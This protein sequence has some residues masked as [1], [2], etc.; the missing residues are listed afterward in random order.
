MSFSS[1]RSEDL[2]A[3]VDDVRAVL[4]LP[5]RDFAG[6][7]PLL[8]G[9]QVFEQARADDVGALADDQR[10]VAV[11]GLHQLDAGIISAVRRADS[12]VRGARP[13]PSARWPGCAQAW[14]RSSRRRCSASHARRTSPAA[15]PAIRASPDTCPLRS[16]ARVGITG[17]RVGGHVRQ[18]ADVIRHQIRTGGAVQ[19]RWPADPRNPGRLKVQLMHPVM[20]VVIRQG[21]TGPAKAV[22][23]DRICSGVEIKPMNV[24]D[25]VRARDDKDFRTVLVPLI[26]D[27]H[28]QRDLMNHGPHGPVEQKDAVI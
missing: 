17:N 6:L 7:F 20:Q 19:G 22:G 12:P 18:R 11:L 8:L 9:D 5:A 10:T 25:D 1:S 23:L 14:S 26:I 21:D 4:H 15:P 13:P 28:R 3:H 27:V 2:Q 16:A 24:L